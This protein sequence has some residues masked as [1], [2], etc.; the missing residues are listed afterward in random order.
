MR[1]TKNIVP[2][3]DTIFMF[4]LVFVMIVSLLKAKSDKE[5]SSYQQQNAA[6]LISLTWEGN[7]DLDLWGKDP[8]GHI[9]GFSRREGG[10][11]SLMSLNR[12]C[13]G[14]GTSEVGPD[15][16]SV[17][18]INEEIITLRGTVQ[19]EYVF[20]VHSYA[21]KGAKGTKAHVKLIKNKPYKVIVENDK[22]FDLDGDE[23]TFF[24][25]TLDKDGNVVGTDTQL[26]AHILPD[27]RQQSQEIG[28]QITN[29]FER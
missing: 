1:V 17:N 8:A 14:A 9:V 26:P 3:I 2:F 5:D 20:N 18:K 23:E 28:P 21:I 10:D 4:L 22:T 16:E 12:D 11:G 6:Y 25:F 7:A 15:G 19:G 27:Q 29:P 24:R 13:L